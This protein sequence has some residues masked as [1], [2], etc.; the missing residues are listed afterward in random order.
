[1]KTLLS[2]GLTTGALVLILMGRETLTARDW[3]TGLVPPRPVRRTVQ[4]YGGIALGIVGL[5]VAVWWMA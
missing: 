4:A 1:M 5:L 2:L 3:R